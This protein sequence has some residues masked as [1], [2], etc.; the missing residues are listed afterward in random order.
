MPGAG[1]RRLSFDQD[2]SGYAAGRPPYPPRVFELLSQIGAVQPGHHI[3]EIGPGTGQATE[4]LIRRGMSVDAVELGTHLANRLRARLPH[5]ELTVTVGDACSV[6]LPK[7][8]YDAVVAATSLHWLDTRSVLP[9]LA[10]ALK[11]RGWLAA[12]WT[13]FGDPE[14][15]T[16][17]RRRVD[18][19]FA[20]QLPD[21]RRE[22][23]EIPRALRVQDRVDELTEG[24]WFVQPVVETIRWSAHMDSRQ[25]QALF[26][27][28]PTIAALAPTR[29]E[30]FLAA[31][32]QAVEAEGGMVD[33]P[34][35]TPVYAARSAHDAD[36]TE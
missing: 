11:P 19:I 3:L 4:E 15:P 13:V 23:D 18:E 6:P 9:L 29:R 2:A 33:D 26:C 8:S 20:E 24:G 27:T 35:V 5:P 21:E 12:W 30:A 34:F 28:F 1:D 25:V 7:A 16:R 22:P 31:L 36:E 14:A 10:R 17:F 32:A